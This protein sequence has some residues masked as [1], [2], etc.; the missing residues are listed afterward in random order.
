MPALLPLLPSTHS[1]EGITADRYKKTPSASEQ[2]MSLTSLRQLSLLL[3]LL[4][5]STHSLKG[6]TTDR[7][8]ET[9]NAGYLRTS[10]TH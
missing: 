3:L 4:L 6:I 7:Q 2:Q 9:R 10:L 1:L 8:K 5:P